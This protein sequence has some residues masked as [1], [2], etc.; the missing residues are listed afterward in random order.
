MNDSNYYCLGSPTEE[1]RLL[2]LLQATPTG[3]LAGQL[4]RVPIADTPPFVSISH[5]WGSEKAKAPMHLKSGCGDRKVSISKNLESLL[6]TLLCH[7]STTLPLLYDTGSRLPLWIDMSCI[8]QTDADEKASQIPLMRR[9]YSQARLVL[10]WLHESDSHLRYAFHYLRQLIQVRP[11]IEEDKL[12]TLFDPLGWDSLSRL[13]A[14][15]W[16][17]RRWVI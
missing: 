14:S 5:V 1:I 8:N 17:Q 4:I 9:I 13:L 11:C 12:H 15:G 7:D 16:F 6:L 10:I 2:H 3:M